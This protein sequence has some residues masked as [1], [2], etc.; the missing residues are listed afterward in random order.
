MK[1]EIEDDCPVL[2]VGK[3]RTVLGC[4]LFGAFDLITSLRLEITKTEQAAIFNTH[5]D[6]RKLFGDPNLEQQKQDWQ[7]QNQDD[8]IGEQNGHEQI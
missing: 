4:D 2:V 6:I 8:E 5:N 3:S 1:L 7:Q